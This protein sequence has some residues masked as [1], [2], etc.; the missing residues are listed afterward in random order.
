MGHFTVFAFVRLRFG[1]CYMV[2]HQVV[3]TSL[4]CWYS[5]VL[6][7]VAYVSISVDCIKVFAIF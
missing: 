4:F 3:S 6:A 2:L 1:V 7:L 5:H